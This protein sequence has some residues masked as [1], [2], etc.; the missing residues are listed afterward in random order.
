MIRTKRAHLA[1]RRIHL[2]HKTLKF[3]LSLVVRAPEQLTPM[4]ELSPSDKCWHKPLACGQSWSPLRHSAALID[5]VVAEARVRDPA[6]LLKDNIGIKVSMF[7][8]DFIVAK[9]S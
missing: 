6:G 8:R 5:E 4:V 2:M 9:L 1:P 7:E 3:R